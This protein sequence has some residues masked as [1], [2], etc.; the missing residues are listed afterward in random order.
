[1]KFLVVKFSSSEII[2]R[3]ALIREILSREVIAQEVLS[4]EVFNREVLSCE[5]LTRSTSDDHYT[6]TPDLNGFDHHLLRKFF[7]SLVLQMTF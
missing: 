3:E 4:L 2:S 6:A 1:M 7:H 5:S